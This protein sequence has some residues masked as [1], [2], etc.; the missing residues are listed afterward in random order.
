MNKV[1]K[2]LKS[3]LLVLSMKYFILSDWLSIYDFE[4]VSRDG[5]DGRILSITCK[6]S[7]TQSTNNIIL[8]L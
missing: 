5:R 2:I 3:K 4:C 8:S 6:I 1:N 7:N